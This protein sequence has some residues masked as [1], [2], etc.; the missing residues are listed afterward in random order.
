MRLVIWHGYLLDGTGSNVYTREVARAWAGLGHDVRVIC[1]ESRPEQVELAGVRVIRPDIGPLLP[2]FV[3]DGYEGVTAR[4]VVGHVGG[5]ARPLPGRERAHAG[6]GAGPRAGRGGAGQSRDHGRPGGPRGM[7]L[8]G[9]PLRRQAAR[10]GARVR[11]SR[12]AAAGRDGPARSGRGGGGVRRLAAHR[13]RGRRAAGRRAVPGSPGGRPARSRHGRLP[14]RRR[15]ARRGPP[16]ARGRPA[17]GTGPSAPPTRIRQP[18][19]R[20]SGDSSSTSAS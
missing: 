1:A 8:L 12:R 2:V 9:N 3:V 14:A 15:L 11:D 17:G 6:R 18:A 4:H 16:A 13:R 20:G 19:W 5:R 7:C 10:L